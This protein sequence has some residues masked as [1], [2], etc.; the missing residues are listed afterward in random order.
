MAKSLSQWASKLLLLALCI[1]QLST[2]S[3]VDAQ[4]LSGVRLVGLG[5]RVAREGRLEVLY[6]N[7]WG[8][9]C[10]DY[11][12]NNDNGA[13]VACF[14]LGYGRVGRVIGNQYGPGNGTIWLDNVQCTGAETSLVDCAHNAFGSSDCTH[15]ED[16]SISCIDVSTTPKPFAIPGGLV[17]IEVLPS[18]RLAGSTVARKGRLEVQYNNVWGTVCYDNFGN[19]DAA[20]ACNALG[21][22][23]VGQPYFNPTGAGTGQIWLDEMGCVGDETSLEVCSHNAWG[24][25]DCSHSEDVWLNCSGVATV[26]GVRL[27][28]SILFGR[29]RLEINYNGVWGTVCD[30][31]FGNADA[32]VACYMLGYG[33][34]HATM[35]YNQYGPG[36]GIIWM[37]DVACSGS[38]SSLANCG[39]N[40]WGV[41]NCGHAEDVSIKCTDLEFG[42]GIRLAG[43]TVARK[44]R[45][46][47]YH[48]LTWGTV[49][50]D[51]FDNADVAVACSM[52]GFGLVGQTYY[53]ATGAGTGQIWLDEMQCVGD[54]TTLGSCVHNPWGSH[55]C[56]HY[57]DVWLDCSGVSTVPPSARLAG[58][59]SSSGT[60]YGI[61]RLEINYN[62]VWGTV[63]GDIFDNTDAAVACYMLGYDGGWMV[64]NQYGP[65]TGIIWL[66]DV[67]CS[68]SEPS[69][70]NCGHNGWGVHNCDHSKDVA[71]SCYEGPH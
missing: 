30:D 46:E 57:E 55:D 71:I 61:G 4:T 2:I 39:H 28:G 36:T 45:L 22:G 3:F 66:D 8:T 48:N 60:F 56:T 19:A 26:Q 69:L 70:A 16:V 14:M 32:A 50:D 65:G 42:L 29:G 41:H 13:R 52:L 63:C 9:V 12:N 20:V 49:C 33:R 53:N 11:F 59:G 37:D 35:I 27:A 21:Y 68:G 1:L 31:N 23:R 44:G 54:E 51:N 10:D 5:I 17:P 67:A 7:V 43:S 47:V 18:V 38:E 62:G 15:S 34:L 58:S 64:N 25:H 24:S 40:G 6:N